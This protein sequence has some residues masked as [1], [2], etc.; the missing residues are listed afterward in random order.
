MDIGHVQYVAIDE[1]RTSTGPYNY[2]KA[3]Y[4]GN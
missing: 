2:Q 4:T 1:I 3:L